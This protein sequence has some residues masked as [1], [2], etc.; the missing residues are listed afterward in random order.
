MNGGVDGGGLATCARAEDVYARAL[1]S[2]CKEVFDQLAI[3]LVFN[4]SE[5]LR[6]EFSNR[7]GFIEGHAVI[8]FSAAEVAR[9]A[10]RLKDWFELRFEIYTRF[11]RR[12]G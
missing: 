11:R 12:R 5:K 9:H 4:A 8:H 10:F 1:R 6:T 7:F 2:L 3:V